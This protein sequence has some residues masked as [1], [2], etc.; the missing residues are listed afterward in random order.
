MAEGVEWWEGYQWGR[1]K[2]NIFFSTN[3]GFPKTHFLI[4]NNFTNASPFL[5][6]VPTLIWLCKYTVFQFSAI[7]KSCS[8]IS[9][10]Q[11]KGRWSPN[12]GFW[13][14]TLQALKTCTSHL[15]PLFF[16]FLVCKISSQRFLPGLIN[17]LR[18][19]SQKNHKFFFF[20]LF[21]NFT[22]YNVL[23]WSK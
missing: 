4:C 1:R 13:V 16:C 3:W 23:Y 22:L 9:A 5:V 7:A 11:W 6:Y 14:L 2:Q 21:L 17:V 8:S 20:A 19:L 15:S 18:I 12:S 10:V